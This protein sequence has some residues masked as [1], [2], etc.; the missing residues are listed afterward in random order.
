MTVYLPEDRID[1]LAKSGRIIR[2]Q[3]YQCLACGVRLHDRPDNVR[4]HSCPACGLSYPRQR[5]VHYHAA[6]GAGPVSQYQEDR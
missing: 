5:E 4:N 1:E 3:V 6:D 2:C